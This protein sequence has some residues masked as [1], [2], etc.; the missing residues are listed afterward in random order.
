MTKK[1]NEVFQVS[2]YF[3]FFLVHSVQ[4]GVGILGFQQSLVAEAGNDSWIVVIL[5]GIGVHIIIWI[6]YQ[7]LNRA[8]MDLI[9]IHKFLFGK[10]LGNFFSLIWVAYFTSV[11]IT[12]LFSYFEV[13]RVWMFPEIS[14][15]LMSLLFGLLVLYCVFGGFRTVA[16]ICF[17]GVVIPAYLILTFFF[18]VPYAD[19]LSLLPVWNHSI[20]EMGKASQEMTLSYLGFSTILFYYP[21]IKEAKSSQKWAQLGALLTMLTYLLIIVI[22]LCYFSEEQLSK[23]LWAT[24]TLWKIVEMPVVERFE[25]IGITSWAVII[26][27]NVCLLFWAASR[28]FKK[29]FHMNQKH[30]MMGIIVLVLI[31]S[32]FFIKREDILTLSKWT[33]RVG[34]YSEFVYVPIL[35]LLYLILSKVRRKKNE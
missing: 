28:G 31:L 7:L 25:Y 1:I 4:V 11:G 17:L 14:V 16:G 34:L 35:F 24:L 8:Q 5:A 20:Q 23:Q 12:V 9:D 2:P 32:F 22:S 10:W 13:I 27:P 21:F 15:F 33:T 3:V 6:I 26:L 30:A 19:F 29:I 18:P